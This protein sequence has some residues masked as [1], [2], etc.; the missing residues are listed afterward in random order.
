[1]P[2]H[3]VRKGEIR[4]VLCAFGASVGDIL[5]TLAAGLF[6]GTLE[7]EAGTAHGIRGEGGIRWQSEG[8][9]AARNAP[10]S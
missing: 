4:E 6:C 5:I 2:Q 1:M 3:K 9:R 10:R 7:C 8:Q